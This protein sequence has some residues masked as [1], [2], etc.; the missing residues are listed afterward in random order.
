MTDEEWKSPITPKGRET[1]R[2]LLDAG[3]LIAAR[4]GLSDLSV[5]A[6]TAEAGVA[7]GTF[8]IHFADRARFVEALRERFLSEVEEAVLAAVAP[9][10]PGRDFLLAAIDS[11]LDVCL[12]H[13]S[14]KTL[15]LEAGGV[16]ESGRPLAARFEQ[17]VEP[18]LK[19]LGL[20]PVQI[21]ARLLIALASETAAIEW[22]AATRD[23][24]ARDA[25]RRWILRV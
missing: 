15:T 10:P 3:E 13:R 5:A 17:L 6:V 12:A 14:V 2:A 9:H 23:S 16:G 24:G 1:T 11:Y 7:K 22:D 25:L 21:N 20:T 19:V 8:Y 18:S 4:D